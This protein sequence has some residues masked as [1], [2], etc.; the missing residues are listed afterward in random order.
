MP[1]CRLRIAFVVFVTV[2]ASATAS[3]TLDFRQQRVLEQLQQLIASSAY[4]SALTFATSVI[5]TAADQGPASPWISTA[6]A[7]QK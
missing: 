6:R 5:E 7:R 3:P 4:D 2:V 1:N